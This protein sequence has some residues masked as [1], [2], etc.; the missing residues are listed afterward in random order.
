M[1]T[2]RRAALGAVIAAAVGAIATLVAVPEARDLL[3]HDSGEAARRPRAR[4]AEAAL[5]VRRTNAE[6]VVVFVSGLFGDA[7][8]AWTNPTTG[9]YWPSLLKADPAFQN[10]DIYVYSPASPYFTS[11]VTVDD[12]VAD[13]HSKLTRD[14][15]F[16]AH[17]RIVFLGHSTGGILIRAFLLQHREEGSKVPLI[18]LFST[19]SVGSDLARISQALK[20]TDEALALQAPSG[21]NAYLQNIELGWRAARATIITRC[22]YETRPFGSSIVVSRPEATGLCDGPIDVLDK[23]HID[24]VKPSDA[25]DSPYVAFLRAFKSDAFKSTPK[26]VEFVTVTRE[27][28][29]YS[30][31]VGCGEARDA[32]INVPLNIS[33]EDTVVSVAASLRNV[34][35]LKDTF[36]AVISRDGPN[37]VVR[38][39]ASGLD[40]EWTGNCRGGGHGTVVVTY[41]VNQPRE[42][43][44]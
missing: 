8:S 31:N 27:I 14:E 28:A 3:H 9:A 26:P 19:P 41:V 7:Q 44:Q 24:I 18:Y 4:A 35:N 22:A 34:D 33:A 40:R 25:R 23:N 29:P 39:H 11:T 42:R 32:N 15:V 16:A 5:Y 38:V 43:P 36:T 30:F 12:L 6:T 17:K 20:A 37:A 13:L 2:N 10:T 21:S 1:L